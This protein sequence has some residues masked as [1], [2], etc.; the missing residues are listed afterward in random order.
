MAVREVLKHPAVETVTLVD[1]D[2]EVTKLF[3]DNELLARINSRSLHS[4]KVTVENA[5][6]FLWLRHTDRKFDLIVADFPDP[7]NF[8]IGKLYSTSFYRLLKAALAEEGIAVIQSSSPLIARRSFWC[9]VETLEQVGLTTVPY[10]AFV[11]SFGEWGFVLASK[12][13]IVPRPITLSGLRFLTPATLDSLLQFP[14]D[15]QKVP[16]EAN[17]LITQSL[18]RY[19]DEEWGAYQ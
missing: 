2:R 17:E 6:A 8:S 13:P 14:D 15:M 19:F 12:R 16:V 9:I 7:T 11:P 18:V 3:R 1:L 5:D 4:P 10:H